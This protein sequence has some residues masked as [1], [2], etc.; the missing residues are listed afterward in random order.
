MNVLL[1][2]SFLLFVSRAHRA[3]LFDI[4]RP[5]GAGAKIHANCE[6]MPRIC[7][8]FSSDIAAL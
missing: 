2:E 7:Q 1:L 4:Y 5:H 6:I 8:R 3:G